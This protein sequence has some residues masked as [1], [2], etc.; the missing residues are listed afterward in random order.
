LF[1]LTIFFLFLLFKNS[2]FNKS[3]FFYSY[4]LFTRAYNFLNFKFYIDVIY[5]Y[6]IILFL[7]IFFILFEIIEKG[8]LENFGPHG[9][10]FFSYKLS[11]SIKK[12]H[13]GYIHHYTGVIILS[14]L[15]YIIF[16]LFFFF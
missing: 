14:L 15:Y 3:D 4:V 7:Q 5:N 16:F 9:I 13:T 1:I 10:L 8:L 6:I 2:F 12:F 11:C